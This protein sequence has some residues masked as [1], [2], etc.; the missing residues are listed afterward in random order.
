[1]GIAAPAVIQSGCRRQSRLAILS[2]DLTHDR[3]LEKRIARE[4]WSPGVYLWYPFGIAMLATTQVARLRL[5]E[6]G[7]EQTTEIVIGIALEGF[8]CPNSGQKT[9]A[10]HCHGKGW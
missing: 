3:H 10:N 8:L 5:N 4:R 9:L 1:M 2:K 7:T 6:V